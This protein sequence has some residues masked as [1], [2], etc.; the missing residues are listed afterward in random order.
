MTNYLVG[1]GFGVEP[2][3]WGSTFVNFWGLGRPLQIQL[4]LAKAA[5]LGLNK[6]GVINA[7]R[8]ITGG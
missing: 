5:E 4:S 2:E 7:G 3:F 6:W 8:G 1:P